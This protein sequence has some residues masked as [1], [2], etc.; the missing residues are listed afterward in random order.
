MTKRIL[1]DFADSI[2]VCFYE[3]KGEVFTSAFDN[4]HDLWDFLCEI[5]AAA[6]ARA[7]SHKARA[8]AHE[9]AMEQSLALA[10]AA[11]VLSEMPS[12]DVKFLANLHKKSGARPIFD[13][14][15]VE[16]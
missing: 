5:P 16:F 15:K 8:K 9:I 4:K 7:A 1:L 11:L 13:A 3:V 10:E 12:S 14:S 6:E 2:A